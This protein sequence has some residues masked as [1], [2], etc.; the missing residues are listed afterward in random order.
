MANRLFKMTDSAEETKVLGSDFAKKISKLTA[1]KEARVVALK[2]NLGS[3]KTTFVLGFLRYFGIKPHASSPTF[4]ILKSYKIKN[5]KYKVD[6]IHHLDA[7]RLK[8]K[9]DLDVLEFDKILNNPKNIVLIEWPERIKG[10]RFENKTIVDF[11]YGKNEN[12]RK[13]L[14]LR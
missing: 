14:F 4:V 3:G 5:R 2:G 7:Y 11:H 8:S 1:K 10:A 6:K 13:I 9:K 12:E